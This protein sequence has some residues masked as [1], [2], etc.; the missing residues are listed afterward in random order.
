MGYRTWVNIN[1]VSKMEAGKLKET[2]KKIGLATSL[3]QYEIHSDGF[4]FEDNNGNT[5]DAIIE[6][7]KKYPSILFEGSIDGTSEDSSDLRE[8]R[9]KGGLYEEVLAKIRYPRFETVTSKKE[10]L[11]RL[12]K[13]MSAACAELKECQQALLGAFGTKGSLRFDG[14]TLKKSDIESWSE[15][16]EKI[17]KTVNS[18]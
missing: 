18:I 17:D 2:L 7:S 14:K 6:E 11:K 13:D 8:F 9:L 16:L 5:V 4:E 10:D 15:T 12:F 1:A 3:G